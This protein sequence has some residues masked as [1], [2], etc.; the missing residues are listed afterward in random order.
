M[1]YP[2]SHPKQEP[3]PKMRKKRHSGNHLS[4][5]AAVSW[6]KSR[7]REIHTFGTPLLLGSFKAKMTNM[8]NALA[9]NSEKNW[10]GLVKK[11]CGYVQ[12]MAAVAFEAGG[13][14]RRPPSK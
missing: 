14:V 6:G 5:Y 8:S 1:A 11:A 12:N 2:V 4:L 9:I 7:H 3:R 10:L 13:T